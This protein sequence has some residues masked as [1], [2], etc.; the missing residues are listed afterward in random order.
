MRYI[1]AL[2]AAFSFAVNAE[3]LEIPTIDIVG[4]T[5]YQVQQNVSTEKFESSAHIQETAPGLKSPYIGAFTGNQVNQT[6]D[7]IRF[8]NALFR[9]GP[10]QYYSWIPD[11]FTESI[12]ISDGGNIGGTIDRRLGI[13]PSHV[14]INY[15]GSLGFTEHMS[16]K[17]DKFGVALNNINHK[18]V[19]TRKGRIPHSA[20]NQQAGMFEAY[21]NPENKTTFV[22]THSGD[23]ERT[24]K[25]N[26]GMRE[27]GYQSP[28]IYTWEDQ[29]YTLIKHSSYIDN[30]QLDLA[31]Q[32]SEERILDKTK[33]IH[34]DL[35]AYTING[36]YFFSNG[37]SLYSTNTMEKIM[38]NNG[39]ETD[40]DT[41]YTTKQGVRWLGNISVIDVVASLGTKQVNSDESHFSNPE[42]SIILGYNGWFTSYDRSSNTP[43][44]FNLNQSLTSG[45]GEMLP[46]SNL[47]EEYADTY[48][49]GYKKYGLYADV[50]KKHLS[51]VIQN[52]T[53]TSSPLVYQAYNGGTTDVYGSTLGY[54]NLA[55]MNSYWGIDAKVEY[56]YGKN[57][58]PDGTTE[59]TSKTPEWTSYAK[60]LYDKWWAEFKYQAPTN[61]ISSSDMNDVRIYGHNGGYKVINIG[62]TTTYKNIDY[63]AALMNV[64]NDDGRV[65][66]SSVDVP[67]RSLFFSLNYNF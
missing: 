67:E 1:T 19:R 16:Y 12:G 35:D 14:G 58:L 57:Y 55:I 33:H 40:H 60:L 44:Y 64:T 36:E 10:N 27:S 37:F 54:K 34:S 25:W 49:F 20:Y 6:I 21:W 45:R 62:Y 28:S 32:N 56:A 66:G 17:N 13:R 47:K 26:G 46:N 48:R 11:A 22:K 4:S 30:L 42:G 41:W 50:Y 7:G 61:R 15:L 29:D 23:L 51:D 65:Y 63:T 24:D 9:T 43:S 18:D 53:I 59:P 3:D 39:T 5:N 2:V 8:N 38:Y 31:Y 52:R